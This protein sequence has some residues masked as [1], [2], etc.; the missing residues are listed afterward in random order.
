MV[1]APSREVVLY[2]ACPG[3]ITSA[4]VALALR[5]KGVTRVRP[6]AGGLQAWRERGFP[7]TSEVLNLPSPAV[8][9]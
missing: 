8:R 6:L 4:R 3:D 1:I 5:A 7:V 9:I 2:C